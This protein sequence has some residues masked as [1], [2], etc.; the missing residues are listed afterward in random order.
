MNHINLVRDLDFILS[1]LV[2]HCMALSRERMIYM[3]K[4]VLCLLYVEEIIGGGW[5][6]NRETSNPGKK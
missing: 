6:R 1:V 2:S 4:R 3:F 5:G